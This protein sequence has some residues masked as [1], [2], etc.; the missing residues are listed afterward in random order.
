MCFSKKSIKEKQGISLIGLM[1]AMIVLVIYII[2]NTMCNTITNHT[3]RN[4]LNEKIDSIICGTSNV[5]QNESQYI[6]INPNT[7]D[8]IKSTNKYVLIKKKDLTYILQQNV[9]DHSS[10]MDANNYLAIILTLIT[11]CVTL[12]AVIPYI[13]GKSILDKDIKEAL[14]KMEHK[15]SVKYRKLV[16][17]LERAEAHLS[18]MTAYTLMAEYKLNKCKIGN[19]YKAPD[20]SIHPSWVIGWAS[21]AIIRY[22][23]CTS[24]GFATDKFMDNCADYIKEASKEIIN[25]NMSCDKDGIVLRAFV[26]LYDAL[27]LNNIYK[28]REFQKNVSDL[29]NILCQLWV[30]LK[31]C[32]E[33]KGSNVDDTLFDLIKQKTK[34]DEYL[35]SEATDNDIRK[36][37]NEW[38]SSCNL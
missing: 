25:S 27:Q 2:A 33:K 15:E 8:S 20:L 34:Y 17:Q 21:K 13:M 24:K 29:E 31:K 6:L 3:Y 28:P 32:Y 22:Q 23:K 16:D 5:I 37:F 9:T 38:K 36:R 12:A 18:R 1:V 7:N 14:E 30:K 26:D 10:I 4:K 35:H 19:S 11:L